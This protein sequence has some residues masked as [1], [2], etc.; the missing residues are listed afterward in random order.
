MEY[1]EY[2]RLKIPLLKL[3]FFIISGFICENYELFPKFEIFFDQLQRL[4][5]YMTRK[6]LISF[7]NRVWF[8]VYCQLY[9]A[10]F[11]FFSYKLLIWFNLLIVLSVN[12]LWLS[13]P[14]SFWLLLCN[15]LIGGEESVLYSNLSILFCLPSYGDE[16]LFFKVN[17]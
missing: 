2:G 16:W 17:S 1:F 10:K 13:Y 11:I 15:F 9:L 3:F 6:S 12:C 4:S 7:Y 14:F 5:L 8:Y